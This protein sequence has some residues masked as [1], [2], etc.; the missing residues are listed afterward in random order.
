MNVVNIAVVVE[1]KGKYTQIKR[2]LKQKTD[3]RHCN[4]DLVD[5]KLI[6]DIYTIIA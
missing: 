2:I 1:K 4:V 6:Y 5:I 3:S